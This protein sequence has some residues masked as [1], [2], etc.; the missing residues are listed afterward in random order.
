M[1]SGGFF[2]QSEKFVE[3]HGGRIGDISIYGQESNYTTW[4]LARMRPPGA[5]ILSHEG[6]NVHRRALEHDE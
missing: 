4:K 6:R 5:G 3:S 2:V 1:G